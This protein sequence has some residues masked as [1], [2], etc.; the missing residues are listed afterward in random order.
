MRILIIRHIRKKGTN[1]GDAYSRSIE[2]LLRASFPGSWIDT[3]YGVLDDSPGRKRIRALK[4]LIGFIFTGKAAKPLYFKTGRCLAELQE[5]NR[6]NRYD[7]VV[8]D[9]V[10][11]LWTLDYL[12]SSSRRIC[13]SQNVESKLYRAFLEKKRMPFFL[14]SF[15]ARDIAAFSRFEFSGIDRVAR[16][17]AISAGD[18]DVYRQNCPNTRITVVPP[19]F[20]YIPFNYRARVV[21][22]LRLG[23]LANF[24]WWPN[25]NGMDWFFQFVA[26][27]IT[28]PHEINC[29]GVGSERYAD[30][31]FCRV[32][33][34]VENIHDIWLQCDVMIVPIHQGGG[35]NVKLAESLYNRMPVIS[36]GFAADGLRDAVYRGG[37]CFISDQANDWAVHLNAVVA[38]GLELRPQNDALSS[39]FNPENYVDDLHDL[40][41]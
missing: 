32:H 20:T 15:F 2:D 5:L 8:I 18:A 28:V 21:N 27:S 4:A 25:R 34:F 33:G 19:L 3:V 7:L 39:Y 23:M 14:R 29:F 38:E 9:H 22:R 24:N 10:E 11:M 1:G 36:T 40:L 31:R 37:A 26:P 12:A 35:V 13:V 30:Q 6:K 16:L 17:I 41:K